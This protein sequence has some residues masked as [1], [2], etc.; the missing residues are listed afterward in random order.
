MAGYVIGMKS[1]VVSSICTS[2]GP[3]RSV[4]SIRVSGSFRRAAFLLLGAACGACGIRYGFSQGAFPSHIH[5]IAVLPFENQ[6]AT[7]ELQSELFEHMRHDVQRRLGVRDAAQDKAD[8][9]VR[10]TIVSYDVD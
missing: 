9:L 7:P 10:G 8:A 1:V 4:H 6:T 5:T 3:T 2:H